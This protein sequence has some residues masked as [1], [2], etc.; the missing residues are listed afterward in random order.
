MNIIRRLLQWLLSFFQKS[1]TP[2]LDAKIEE[3]K[4]Q[5]KKI[6]EKL[7]DKYDNVDNSMGE[8]K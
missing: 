2:E 3:R 1:E 5:I 7:K 8:W 6:D 4:E